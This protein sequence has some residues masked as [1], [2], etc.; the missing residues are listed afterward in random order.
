MGI[1]GLR[2]GVVDHIINPQYPGCSNLYHL[3][4]CHGQH[5]SS[6]HTDHR[7]YHCPSGV[8]SCVQADGARTYSER[9]QGRYQNARQALSSNLPRREHSLRTFTWYRHRSCSGVARAC[10]RAGPT[11]GSTSAN[12]ISPAPPTTDEVSR[13][14]ASETFAFATF[15]PDVAQPPIAAVCDQYIRP[16]VH[17]QAMYPILRRSGGHV[18][19][20]CGCKRRSRPAHVRQA[21]TRIQ[22]HEQEGRG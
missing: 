14:D 12:P 7:R 3:G 6:T 2:A 20:T 9:L 1:E 11:C 10:S 8:S 4:R 18:E 16:S 15:F 21:A 5:H 19:R 17:H 13:G 22:R